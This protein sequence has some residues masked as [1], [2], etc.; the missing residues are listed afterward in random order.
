MAGGDSWIISI[1]LIQVLRAL[2]LH[3]QNDRTS[4]IYFQGTKNGYSLAGF[5][6]V[7]N[8]YQ[9]GREIICYQI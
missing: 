5:R 4:Q 6:A 2:T 1:L 3:E 8:V 7:G 9:P